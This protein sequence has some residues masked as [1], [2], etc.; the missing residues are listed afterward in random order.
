MSSRMYEQRELCA[1]GALYNGVARIT[2]TT[3]VARMLRPLFAYS[4]LAVLP[5]A[6]REVFMGHTMTDLKEILQSR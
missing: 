2:G 6:R 4:A 3:P 1:T 5:I